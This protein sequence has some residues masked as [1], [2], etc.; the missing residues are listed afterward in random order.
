MQPGEL[1]KLLGNVSAPTLRR[2]GKTY[3]RF[4]SPGASPPR[5]KPRSITE[6]DARVLSLIAALR[7]AGQD[8]N[9]IIARLEAEEGNNWENLPP[10]PNG[11]DSA[12]TMPV[13]LAAARAA[14]LSEA[15]ALRT[16]IQ[17]L[18]QRKTELA[19]LLDDAL[20][21]LEHSQKELE[22][23]R[24]DSNQ[25]VEERDQKIDAL[26]REIQEARAEVALLNGK[27]S[28]YSLGRDKPVNVAVIVTSALAFGAVLVVILLV[29]VAIVLS[30]TP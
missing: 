22:S 12:D 27:L 2:W 11:W 19:N 21:R 13:S 1:S 18:E 24:N 6:H 20:A 9:A 14:E 3:S 17:Y 30:T 7:D 16:Q 25:R 26:Q 29:V 5:G 15:A 28:A 8:H 10:L 23:V 4:L